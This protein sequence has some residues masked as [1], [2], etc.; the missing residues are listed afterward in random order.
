VT[1]GVA[2]YKRGQEKIQGGVRKD[3]AFIKHKSE[4]L[5]WKKK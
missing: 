2:E 4:K 5:K 1:K 3:I